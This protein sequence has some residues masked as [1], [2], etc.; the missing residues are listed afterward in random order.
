MKNLLPF[1]IILL[2]YLPT[3]AQN[4]LTIGEVFDFSIGDIFHY[5]TNVTHDGP[6][7]G[8]MIQITDKWFSAN[9]DT[10]YYEWEET[11]FYTVFTSI[12]NHTLEWH[13]YPKETKTRGYFNLNAPITAFD[14]GFSVDTI[15]FDTDSSGTAINYY[16]YCVGSFEPDCYF[17]YYG[18][19][20]G[21]MEQGYVIPSNQF[22]TGERLVYY[23][24]GAKQ[25]GAPWDYPTGISAPIA[26]QVIPMFPNPCTQYFTV[27]NNQT[28]QL[29][30]FN[31]VGVVVHT[32]QLPPGETSINVSTLPKGQYIAQV[33]TGTQLHTQI[34]IKE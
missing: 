26:N 10:V 30:M 29:T 8:K 9:N 12:T 27:S 22:I 7:S 18:D 4:V 32:Q 20:L 16:S 14:S 28:A 23:K 5:K 6:P 3:S 34:I 1:V 19:G 15:K 11:S 31:L 25:W 17:G 33:K 13:L 24:K 2:A 21:V